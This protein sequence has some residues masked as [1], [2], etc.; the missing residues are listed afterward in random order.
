VKITRCGI[1][2]T[3]LFLIAVGVLVVPQYLYLSGLKDVPE[4]LRPLHDPQLTT[5]TKQ[6][7]WRFLGGEDAPEIA[8]KS[9]HG[10]IIDFFWPAPDL[11]SRRIWS[12]DYRLLGEAARLVMF[13]Q[14]FS[15]DW[16]LSNAAAAIWISRNWTTDEV[17]ST[18]LLE[19]YF[20]HGFYG[21]RAAAQG[22][23]DTEL[24]QISEEQ[25][26]YLLVIRAATSR[27]DPWCNSETHRRRF[28]IFA[29]KMGISTAH[30]SIALVPPPEGRCK[31]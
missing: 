9:P 14:K 16:H 18:V 20:G 8:R 23:L 15:G 30:N 12:A 6:A 19:S 27:Y 13:R 26:V 4:D 28:E 2:L 31:Q 7:Y 22:Y 21:I 25:V 17:L 11:E 29:E 5:S 1:V 24:S 3:L 10:F